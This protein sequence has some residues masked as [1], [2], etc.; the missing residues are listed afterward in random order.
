MK[1]KLLITGI[2]TM[3]II[4]TLGF[5]LK[6]KP[7]KSKSTNEPEKGIV[8]FEPNWKKV[9]AEAKKKNKLIFIDAYTT[10]CGPCKQLKKN[11]FPDKAVG[12]F[13]N[14]NFINVAFDMEK[15]D[16]LLLARQYG[17]TAFP[18]LIITDA[19]GKIVTYTLGFMR[20]KELIDFGKQSLTLK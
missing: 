16:G 5:V 19:D 12:E 15:G 17:V 13:F 20:P 7:G 18:T 8:F 9:K 3:L 10:W 4:I 11:T 6:A 2:A 1:N 14:E